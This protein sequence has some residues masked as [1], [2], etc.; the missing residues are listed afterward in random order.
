MTDAE[1]ITDEIVD[2]AMLAMGKQADFIHH[3]SLKA[4]I[5]AIQDD[6]VRPYRN[7]FMGWK[8]DAIAYQ[9]AL[10]EI[11]YLHMGDKD[12]AAYQASDAALKGKYHEEGIE[13]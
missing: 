4:A 2:K 1:L 13:E 8:R 9:K 12:S 7:L 3:N 5:L 6:I 11:R 10:E